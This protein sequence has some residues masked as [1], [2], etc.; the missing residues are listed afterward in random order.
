MTSTQT[1]T[2]RPKASLTRATSPTRATRGAGAPTGLK[3]GTG[4]LP[5]HQPLPRRTGSKQVTSIRGR[6]VVAPKADPRYI[7]FTVLVIGVLI[8]GIVG[9]LSLAGVTTHQSY[10]IA[11]LQGLDA[12]LD[13]QLETLHRDHEAA[14]SAADMARRASDMGMV[15]ADQPGIIAVGVDDQPVTVRQPD[16]S[17]TRPIID[18]NGNRV[19]PLPATSDPEETAALID[20]LQAIPGNATPGAA[21]IPAVAPYSPNIR[22]AGAGGNGQ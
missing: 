16:A 2:S 15:V 21:A 11:H 7:R 3:R 9:T 10:Q 22:S 17:K 6:R 13:N 1:R 20:N 12:Q 5:G 19:R 18:V 14:R 4:Y 8:G